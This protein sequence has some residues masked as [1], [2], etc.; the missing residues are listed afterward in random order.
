MQKIIGLNALA[1]FLVL[2]SGCNLTRSFGEQGQYLKAYDS[3][4]Y[5]EYKGH[6]YDFLFEIG[7][8]KYKKISGVNEGNWK[9][10]EEDLVFRKILAEELLKMQLCSN[11]YALEDQGTWGE[12]PIY[13]IEGSCK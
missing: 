2:C 7:W 4:V 13:S 1:V 3:S 9:K 8:D 10:P 11:G 12:G 6:K 5:K